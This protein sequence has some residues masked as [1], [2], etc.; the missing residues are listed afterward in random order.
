MIFDEAAGSSRDDRSE[1]EP[2]ER[3]STKQT[4]SLSLSFLFSRTLV[5]A[6]SFLLPSHSVF[7]AE[8]WVKVTRERTY[9]FN[10]FLSQFLRE[11]THS[12]T[13]HHR[14]H[15]NASNRR[16]EPTDPSVYPHRINV[17]RY[18]YSKNRACDK[19]SSGTFKY[20]PDYP[21][22]SL[23]RGKHTVKDLGSV[24]IK[25]YLHKD[26]KILLKKSDAEI[27]V[28]KLQ[29]KDMKLLRNLRAS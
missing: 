10:V 6:H 9:T 20:N 24:Y 1:S 29:S 28:E 18:Y 26:R 13:I 17:L 11:R 19:I 25:S 4:F 8:S 12:P 7:E 3:F 27:W 21:R 2:W 15:E 22:I 16:N 14:N 5:F 23:R